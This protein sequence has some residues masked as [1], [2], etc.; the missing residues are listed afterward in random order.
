MQLVQPGQCGIVG[1]MVLR[2]RPWSGG[3]DMPENGEGLLSGALD[4]VPLLKCP[5][6]MRFAALDGAELLRRAFRDG[7]HFTTRNPR[8]QKTANALLAAGAFPH[9]QQFGEIVEVENRLGLGH[10]KAHLLTTLLPHAEP[11]GS[12]HQPGA[13]H[14][15]E[16]RVGEAEVAPT[17]RQLAH[18]G[19]LPA[20]RRPDD[21]HAPAVRTGQH[22]GQLL[23]FR[24]Q[25]ESHR[26]R[27]RRIRGR[28][29]A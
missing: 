7:E 27:G 5:N 16:R 17:T 22:V 11:A 29:F 18:Q 2:L 15:P 12:G 6:Q 23:H 13:T 21:Q 14:G 8:T 1:R 10:F 24:D 26:W 20:A 19:G 4:E 3:Q 25:I 9:F 28:F